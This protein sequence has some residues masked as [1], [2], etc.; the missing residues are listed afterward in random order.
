MCSLDAYRS[1]A[2]VSRLPDDSFV[3]PPVHPW[4]RIYS[5]CVAASG[6]VFVPTV[7]L[8]IPAPGLIVWLGWLSIAFGWAAFDRKLFW[9]FSFAWNLLMFLFLI[10]LRGGHFAPI[11][12][13]LPRPRGAGR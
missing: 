6:A 8:V 13:Q 12:T 7:V 2:A 1:P 5:G 11:S 3:C 9:W 4:I 10:D